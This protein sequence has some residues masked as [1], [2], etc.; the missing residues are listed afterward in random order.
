MSI[1]GGKGQICSINQNSR[2]RLT[3]VKGI[4]KK[5]IFH[6]SI[7]VPVNNDDIEK[8]RKSKGCP[9]LLDG[10]AVFIKGLKNNVS[11]HGYTRVG[12]ISMEKRQLPIKKEKNEN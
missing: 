4:D 2:T 12:D 5:T 8:I 10:G 6:G 11:V 1:Y 7:I 9:T 3:I